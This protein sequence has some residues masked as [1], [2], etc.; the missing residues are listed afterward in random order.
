MIELSVLTATL[1]GFLLLHFYDT[2]LKDPSHELLGLLLPVTISFMLFVLAAMVSALA[3]ALTRG[4]PPFKR[5]AAFAR[6][7]EDA[8]G[9]MIA[10]GLVWHYL[11][12]CYVISQ[13]WGWFMLIPTA[14]PVV[15][16]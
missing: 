1:D 2:Y 14:I 12:P 6:R 5:L 16:F 9:I 3:I 7:L 8:S 13:F 4:E 10:G 15:F 11:L